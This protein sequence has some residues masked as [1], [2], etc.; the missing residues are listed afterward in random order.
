M[1]VLTEG[2]ALVLAIWGRRFLPPFLLLRK[3]NVSSSSSD[4]SSS[5]DMAEDDNDYLNWLR[6][7][8]EGG[9]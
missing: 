3:S 5:L 8:L 6:V 4:Y 1:L 7:I 2:G 9:T